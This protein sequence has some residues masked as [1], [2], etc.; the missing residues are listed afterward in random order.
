MKGGREIPPPS[1]KEKARL[2]RESE[3]QEEFEAAERERERERIHQL[4]LYREEIAR[5]NRETVNRR[6]SDYRERMNR[7]ACS[8]L[9]GRIK[10]ILRKKNKSNKNKSKR[11]NKQVK[12]KRYSRKYFKR[13]LH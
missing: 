8:I 5:Q 9:G 2:E 4:R 7:S 6:L 13:Y 3:W 11:V 12:N 10:N 1:I